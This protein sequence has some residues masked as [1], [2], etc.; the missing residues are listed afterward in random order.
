MKLFIG[1]F[2]LEQRFQIKN[3]QQK[4]HRASYVVGCYSVYGWI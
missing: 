4:C 3:A 1:A 2:E